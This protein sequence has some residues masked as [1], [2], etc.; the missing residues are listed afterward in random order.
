MPTKARTISNPF[1]KRTLIVW[2]ALVVSMT[3]VSGVLLVLEPAPLAPSMGPV[4]TVLDNGP[5]GTDTLFA[6]SSPIRTGRWQSIV[7][8]HSRT[9]YGSAQTLGQFHQQ[10][11]YGGLIYDFVIGNG[12]GAA[13]GEIQSGYRWDRQLDSLLFSSNEDPD[14]AWYNQHTI[15][16]CLIGNGDQAAFTDM[17]LEQL[18]RLVTALQDR[19]NIPSDRV[20]LQSNLTSTTSPG[21]H[22]PASWFRQ[23]LLNLDV[24]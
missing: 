24:R 21:L 1:E 12:D 11:G 8:D 10:L 23:Q 15:T 14:A 18:V 19:L 16:I 6:T 13:E 2:G 22:F 4:L 5:R 9:T 17:Q 20:L 3:L 7:I